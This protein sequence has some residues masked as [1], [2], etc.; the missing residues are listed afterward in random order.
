[1]KTFII[2]MLYDLDFMFCELLCEFIIVCFGLNEDV[3]QSN[4]KSTLAKPEV[5]SA[6]GIT[7]H[8]LTL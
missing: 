4:L 1:M 7:H 6:D 2:F 8:M 5:S 3:P